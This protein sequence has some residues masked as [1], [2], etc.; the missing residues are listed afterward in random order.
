[1][2]VL[3]CTFPLAIEDAADEAVQH[4]VAETTEDVLNVGMKEATCIGIRGALDELVGPFKPEP[5]KWAC[6]VSR[7]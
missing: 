3:L 5:D 6:Q 1:M 4:E 2:F 7:R